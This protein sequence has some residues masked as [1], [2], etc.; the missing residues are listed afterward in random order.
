MPDFHAPSISE[1]HPLI[2]RS[3]TRQETQGGAPE[4]QGVAIGNPKPCHRKPKALPSETQDVAVGLVCRGLSGRGTESEHMENGFDLRSIYT[5]VQM[6]KTRPKTCHFLP[7]FLRAAVIKRGNISP[8]V[9]SAP[10]DQN[11]SVRRRA[12][13][14]KSGKDAR[15]NGTDRPRCCSLCLV[16]GREGNH[17]GGRR[18]EDGNQEYEYEQDSRDD[19]R[20]L[21]TAARK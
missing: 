14:K 15:Q 13:P 21:S 5:C 12:V 18:V 16:E 6:L 4:I 8:Y 1:L 2:V 11:W 3:R 19:V 17:D 10:E 9:E 7:L 20:W